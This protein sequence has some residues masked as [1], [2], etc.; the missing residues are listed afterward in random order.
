MLE[1]KDKIRRLNAQANE[2]R[3]VLL[4]GETGVGKT[5]MAKVVAMHRCWLTAAFTKSESKRWT[6]KEISDLQQF[7]I[8]SRGS[9]ILESAGEPF[10]E[11][12]IPTLE[13]PLAA[14]QLFGHEKGAFTGADGAHR[15]F[16]GLD[17]VNDILLDEIGY[18]SLEMQRSLLQVLQSGKFFRLK[19]TSPQPAKAR[20]LAATNQDLDKLVDQGKFQEDLWWRLTDH[21][22]YIPPLRERQESI[23]SLSNEFLSR[24]NRTYF[25]KSDGLYLSRADFRWAS[26]YHWPGNVRELEKT[27]GRWFFYR[28]SRSLQEVHQDVLRFV[29]KL[30]A[31][32]M[33]SQCVSTDDVA[34][35]NH[36]VSMLRKAME[37]ETSIKSPQK[38]LD[39][40]V[41]P[42]E[43][44]C[45]E[46][47][48]ECIERL[49][50]VKEG[51][52]KR[53]FQ[54]I[55]PST[56]R[57]WLSRNRSRIV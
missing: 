49:G 44:H 25:A 57:S 56:A 54:D 23:E 16:L 10:R 13:G 47:V 40:I 30:G 48:V 42:I 27:V 39:S 32:A 8:L 20:I 51:D 1:L 36:V 9:G 53:L 19:S 46:I 43:T 37:G 55:S 2:V 21:V 6:A 3:S 45:G 22:L 41:D 29:P 14:S 52:L 34:L 35:R 4:L 33:A 18:A 24:L 50:W 31:S 17:E 5:Y 26:A 11:L 7:Y 15:G 28:G 12:N 38:L